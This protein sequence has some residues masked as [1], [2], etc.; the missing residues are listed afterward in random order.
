M[1]RLITR[2][3]AYLIGK[4]LPLSGAAS[5]LEARAQLI[6]WMLIPLIVA[7]LCWLL[8]ASEHLKSWAVGLSC[9]LAFGGFSVV[10]WEFIIVPLKN[11]VKRAIGRP[12]SDL[13]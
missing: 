3:R 13:D 11:D 9:A 8:G 12:D 1:L 5:S 7:G 4:A 10:F 2:Y 6:P